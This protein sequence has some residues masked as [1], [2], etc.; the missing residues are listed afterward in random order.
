MSV[1]KKPKVGNRYYYGLH[2]I[3]CRK[4]DGVLALRMADKI[5]WEGE[6]GNGF[7]DVDQPEAFGEPANFGGGSLEH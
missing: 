5:V 2:L 4:A 7:I 1:G 6:Q 3:P